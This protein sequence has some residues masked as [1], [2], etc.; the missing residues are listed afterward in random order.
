MPTGNPAAPPAGGAVSQRRA[1]HRPRA[2]RE[3][4]PPTVRCFVA[5][6]PDEAALARLDQL[7]G[8]E[9][10]RFPSARRMRRDNLHLTMAFIGALEADRARELAEALAAQAP[11]PFDWSLDSVGAFAGARVLWV[12]GS[13]AQLDA[14]A[15]RSRRL[16]D[17]LG[18]HFDRKPFVAHVTLLRDLPRA[19]AGEAARRIEPPIRWHAGPPVLLESRTDAS[20]VRYL[21]VAARDGNA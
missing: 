20:G 6:Q 17:D 16:L 10:A 15:A 21:P 7:A 5:L 19:A 9:Q 4:A 8:E 13:D 14:L 11:L 1:V 18:V 2:A 12:G 3:G